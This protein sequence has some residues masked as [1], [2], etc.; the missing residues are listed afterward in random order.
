MGSKRQEKRKMGQST[1]KRWNWEHNWLQHCIVYGLILLTLGTARANTLTSGLVAYWP[2]DG[3]T[4]DVSGHGHKLSGNVSYTVDRNS[5]AGSATAFDGMASLKIPKSLY[6]EKNMTI[7]VWCK[8][9]A[10]IPSE[11]GESINETDGATMVGSQYVLYPS[12]GGFSSTGK[13]G[14]GLVVGQNGVIVLEHADGYCPCP[15]VWSGSIGNK[16]VLVTVTISGN[17]APH[18]Y[19]NGDYVKKGMTTSKAKFVGASDWSLPDAYPDGNEQYRGYYW[20]AIIGNGATVSYSHCPY[21]GLMDD[22]RIYNRALSTSEIKA[23]YEEESVRYHT[24]KFN[25]NDGSE[26][27]EEVKV[28]AGAKL[29]MPVDLFCREGFVFQGWAKTAKGAVEYEDGQEI[30]VSGDMTLFAV[31]S[32]PMTLQAESADWSS[33][34]LTL[35]CEDDSTSAS[36]HKYSLEYCNENDEWTAVDGAKNILATKGQNSS[37]QEVWIA[38]LTDPSFSSRLGGLPPVSYRVV[39]ETGRASEPC[40]TRTKYGIFVGVV[41]ELSTYAT[42]FGRLATSLGKCASANVHVLTGSRAVYDGIDG[43]FKDIAGKIKCGDV[44]FLY[45]GTHGGLHPDSTASSRLLLYNSR[46]YEEREL[47][48]HIQLLNGVDVTNPDG[49]GVAIVGF[50]HACHSKA[51]SD[52]T[53]D[54]YCRIG[55]WCA[56]AALTSKNS[57]W[58]T[59]TDDPQ[60]LSLGEYFSLFLLDYGWEKGWGGDS[61]KPLSCEK[62]VEYTRKQTD[63]LFDGLTMKKDGVS[64]AIKVGVVGSFPM[65][66]NIMIGE[67]GSHDSTD[68]PSNP[69]IVSA[70]GINTSTIQIQAKNIRNA[71]RT[72]LFKR[73]GEEAT[74]DSMSQD[75]L[76]GT[77]TYDDTDVASS[78]RELPY[79]Y[80]IR[81][82]N[83]AGIG[84]SNVES[85]WRVHT[86]NHR[87]TFMFELPQTVMGPG[88]HWWELLYDS[89]LS[90]I[91]SELEKKLADFG[92]EGFVHT[93]WFTE[94]NGRGDRITGETRVLKSVTYYANWTAMTQTWLDSHPMTASSANGDIATAAV[95]T[96]ANGC[97]TVGECYALGINPE[98]PADD[99]RIA[100]FE[101]QDGKPHLTLNH[102]EDGSGKTFLP[103]VRVLGTTVLGESSQWD[104]VTDIANPDA[105]GYRFFKATVE[106]P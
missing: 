84:K 88:G 15:L 51:V 49:N 102:T 85:A 46:Y 10:T 32:R 25:A 69:E 35:R 104:D 72:V 44:C 41:D 96:A 17:G 64:F 28:I 22:F 19:I 59:A 87:V 103:D 5:N 65:L 31:W 56:N 11:I 48:D 52:N 68:L 2:F 80:Q 79:Y 100:Q 16:W 91:W 70:Q 39:D 47:A 67:C 62:L 89:K 57:A 105:S 37:G 43:A 33:G 90:G 83:G 45:F 55:S 30:E 81:T 54:E 21:Y 98:D 7:S 23:L 14:V 99:L 86:E 58:I 66:R 42:T 4:K 92:V 82:L 8:P 101:M 97:R 13:A 9:Y 12:H 71:D 29:A 50:V 74:W 24:V 60:A 77:I 1:M 36:T 106:L 94:P 26:L 40:V 93:G 20:G 78:G 61:G 18:L 6:V 73:K 75:N 27:I 3:N 38:K 34:S 76:T 63:A 53:N 95:M